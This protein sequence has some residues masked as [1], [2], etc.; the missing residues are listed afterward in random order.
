MCVIRD[1]VRVSV[2]CECVCVYVSVCECECVCVCVCVGMYVLTCMYMVYRH[3]EFHMSICS[4]SFDKRPSKPTPGNVFVN[5]SEG[6]GDS[7]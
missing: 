6:K 4:G 3:I 5:I 2:A 7:Q 1:C